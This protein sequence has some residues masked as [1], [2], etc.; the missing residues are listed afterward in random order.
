MLRVRALA[1]FL[2]ACV[3]ASSLVACASSGERPHNGARAA[4][5]LNADETAR[6]LEQGE[7]ALAKG[8]WETAEARFNTILRLDPKHARARLGIAELLLARGQSEKAA[9]VFS[10]LRQIPDIRARASQGL[11]L[12]LLSAGQGEKALSPL[13]QAVDADRTLWRAWNGLGL[14]HAQRGEWAAAES[15]YQRALAIDPRLAPVEN[16][17]GYTYLSQRKFAAAAEHFQ[18]AIAIDSGLKTARGNLRLALAWQ[19]KYIEALADIEP[20]EASSA[21]NNV[22]VVAMRRGDYQAAEQY[23]LRA[24]EASPSFDQTAA[25]NLRRLKALSVGAQTPVPPKP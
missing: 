22:G 7:L 9:A 3:G 11:G 13:R 23:F 17:L 16:N 20:N 14:Y 18:R 6:L 19:G 10:E 1:T 12:A 8:V 24:M 21:L 5:N 15:H 2:A 4:P 25:D